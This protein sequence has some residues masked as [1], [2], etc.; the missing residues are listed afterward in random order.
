MHL[1]VSNSL[2]DSSRSAIVALKVKTKTHHTA[3]QKCRE[4]NPKENDINRFI[5][6][7][8]NIFAFCDL[9]TIFQKFPCFER[10]TR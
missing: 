1:P 5:I 4:A 9:W 2:S 8:V 10:I 7:K 3:K 6:F